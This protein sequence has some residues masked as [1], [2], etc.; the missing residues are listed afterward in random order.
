LLISNVLCCFNSLVCCRSLIH[1][2]VQRGEIKQS[3][4]LG[5]CQCA[6]AHMVRL[7]ASH[8]SRNP[9]IALA[10]PSLHHFNTCTVGFWSSYLRSIAYHVIKRSVV[11]RTTHDRTYTTLRLNAC[12]M[13]ERMLA[14]ARAHCLRSSAPLTWQHTYFCL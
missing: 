1:I 13:I 11:E 2:V 12:Q 10:G 5:P 6:R 14:C 3:W 8:V 7:S 4:N 9:R